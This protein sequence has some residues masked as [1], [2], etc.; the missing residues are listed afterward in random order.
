[1]QHLLA[2]CK[3][4]FITIVEDLMSKTGVV[5][6]VANDVLTTGVDAVHNLVLSAIDGTNLLQNYTREVG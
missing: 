5:L 2:D 6:N 3:T 1:M 4:G